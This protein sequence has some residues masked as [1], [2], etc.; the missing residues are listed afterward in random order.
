MKLTG[1][2]NVQRALMSV[3]TEEIDAGGFERGYNAGIGVAIEMLGFAKAAIS[4]ELEEPETPDEKMTE[5]YEWYKPAETI[6]PFYH[7]VLAILDFGSG[8]KLHAVVKRVVS[9]KGRVTLGPLETETRWMFASSE[10]PV[11]A[12]IYRWGYLPEIPQEDE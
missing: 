3:A 4:S 7:S 1:Y 10:N 12:T 8:T 11:E 2:A 6:P 9:E 5:F